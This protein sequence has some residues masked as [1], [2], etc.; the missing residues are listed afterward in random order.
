MMGDIGEKNA[1]Q[2]HTRKSDLYLMLMLDYSILNTA[3]ELGSS[4]DKHMKPPGW[5]WVSHFKHIGD[6]VQ[7]PT[8]CFF[9]LPKA[10]TLRFA[11]RHFLSMVL[12]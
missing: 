5:V 10:G 12:V 9:S 3:I 2:L 7:Y 4:I 1:N 8:K 6:Q 11:S